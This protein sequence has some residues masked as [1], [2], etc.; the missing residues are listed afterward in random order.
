MAVLWGLSIFLKVLSGGY[1]LIGIYIW[2][3]G[4]LFFRGIYHGKKAPCCYHGR[5]GVK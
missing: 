2:R 4:R 3:Q 5:D 1:V